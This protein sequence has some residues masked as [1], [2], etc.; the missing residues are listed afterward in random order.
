LFLIEPI[1]A[2]LFDARGVL[3][4]GQP[5]SAVA[6]RGTS[7]VPRTSA[8]AAMSGLRLVPVSRTRMAWDASRMEPG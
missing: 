7:L 2:V 4:C 5:A 3:A 6:R 8:T 1:A